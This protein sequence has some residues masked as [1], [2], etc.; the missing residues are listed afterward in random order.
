MGKAS[1]SKSSALDDRTREGLALAGEMV[2]HPQVLPTFA[3][4]AR[5]SDMSKKAGEL[6]MFGQVADAIREDELA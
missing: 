4:I 3:S 5:F 2:R 1:R 6:S